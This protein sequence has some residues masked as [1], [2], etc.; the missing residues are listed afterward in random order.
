MIFL[1]QMAVAPLIMTVA[2]L[3]G[4]AHASFLPAPGLLAR[5]SL[6][7]IC[8]SLGLRWGHAL[9]PL[10]GCILLAASSPISSSSS[11]GWGGGGHG[12]PSYADCLLLRGVRDRLCRGGV[13]T[14]RCLTPIPATEDIH[15]SGLF[16]APLLLV[17]HLVSCGWTSLVSFSCLSREEHHRHHWR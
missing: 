16:L 6:S 14:S 8:A 15:A 5:C 11:K 2:G 12:L 4:V 9:M 10:A 13:H 3:A 1:L 7:S 17:L